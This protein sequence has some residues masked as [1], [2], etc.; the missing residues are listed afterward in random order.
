MLMDHN[1]FLLSMSRT[2]ELRST[3]NRLVAERLRDTAILTVDRAHSDL[4]KAARREELDKE[5]S[6]AMGTALEEVER[7]HR[8]AAAAEVRAGDPVMATFGIRVP[9]AITL[10]GDAAAKAEFRALMQGLPTSSR[11]TWLDALVGEKDWGRAGVLLALDP[12][13][14]ADA[15]GLDLPG[16]DQALKEA[17]ELKAMASEILA[18]EAARKVDERAAELSAKPELTEAEGHELVRLGNQQERAQKVSRSAAPTALSPDENA[19]FELLNQKA[20]AGEALNRSE[21]LE[22]VGLAQRVQDTI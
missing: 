10:E 14:A 6:K 16:R 19:R 13:L 21:G 9:G 2:G 11:R 12:A 4:W 5:F 17:A 20:D 15:K 7:I 1:K 22:L 8:Q 18:D 3:V